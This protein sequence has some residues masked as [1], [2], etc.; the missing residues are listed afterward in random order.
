MT[1]SRFD[2]AWLLKL[3][4][5]V[6][7]CGEMDLAR[8]WN[9]DRQ[10]GKMGASVLRRGFPRTYQFAQARS[11]I[12][13]ARERC[14]Q[15]FM[16]TGCLT[17]WCLPEDTEDAFDANW[18][19]WL[20]NAPSWRPFFEKVAIIR[21]PDLVAALRDFA[22]VDAD[23]IASLDSVRPAADGRSIL[24]PGDFSMERRLVAQLALGFAKAAPGSLVIPYA[25]TP[26]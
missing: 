5:V 10:L 25:R 22:L 14:T 4:V 3:R 12:A 8:W 23:E 2:L 17:L 26:A 15:L 16:P 6:A 7:R 20:D 9:T 19:G 24:I 11:V 1:T 13:A 21:S 18:E